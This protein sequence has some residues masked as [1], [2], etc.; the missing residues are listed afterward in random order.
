MTITALPYV[1]LLGLFFGSS[2]VASRFVVGQFDPATFIALRMLAASALCLIVYFLAGKRLPRDRTLWW[3]AGLLGAFGT[4]APM[5]CIISS[6]QYLSSGLSSLIFSTGPA[7]TIC[8]AHFALPDEL[9]TRRKA[10][11]VGLALGGA[12][13]LAISGEDGLSGTQQTQS[14]GYLL[15]G[16]GMVFTSVM[17]IYARKFLRGYDAYDVGSI[18]IVTTAVVALPYSLLTVGF[19]ASAADGAGVLAL[20]YTALVG[21]FLAFMLSFYNIK[22]FGATAAALA[23]YIIPIVAS[24]GGVLALNEEITQT[25]LAGMAVIIVGIALLQ[26]VKKPAG[27]WRGSPQR[28]A[29]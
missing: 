27:A 5:F 20:G 21:T 13:M 1:A 18:R 28:G 22:R 25:M 2:L 17:V 14:I 8:L 4:A 12:M 6:L 9:L 10:L 19:D 29:Y 15:V 26:E 7:L 11:G 23:S 16:V 3:R 24:V